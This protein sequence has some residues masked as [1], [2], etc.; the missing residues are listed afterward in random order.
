MITIIIIT[1]IIIIMTTMV[2]KVLVMVVNM[3]FHGP[4]FWE[5]LADSW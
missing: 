3:Q 4:G 5:N 2:L 1:T